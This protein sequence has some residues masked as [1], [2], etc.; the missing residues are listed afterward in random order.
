M[1]RS[2]K[3]DAR[4][5]IEVEC[6]EW[7]ELKWI[8]SEYK[9][10]ATKLTLIDCDGYKYYTS[11][12]VIKNSKRRGIKLNKFFRGN[13]YTKS[14]IENYLKLNEINVNLLSD[15]LNNAI[16]K[17]AWEC[18]NH[19]E[20]KLSWNEIKNLGNCPNCGREKGAL[21]KRNTYEYVKEEFKKK[22][23]LLI[24]ESYELNNIDLEYICEKH[25]E[26]GV[27]SIKYANLLKANG[28]RYCGLES[29]KIKQTKTHEQFAEE[30]EE[31][32]GDMYTLVGKYTKGKDNIEVFCN[33]CNNVFTIRA[34]HLTDNHGCSNCNISLGE[35]K[36]KKYLDDNS[37]YYSQQQTFDGC[38]GIQRKLPFDFSLFDDSDKTILKC[39]IEYQGIQ[40]YK[41]VDLFGGKAQLEA[42]Q[43][44]DGIKANYCIEN[45]IKLIVIPYWD[46][47]N[48]E[49]IL[50]LELSKSF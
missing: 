33:K 2:N 35:N 34:S 21:S 16:E 50:D 11:V 37:F 45:D 18:P 23:L 12:S 31:L 25:P 17:L 30:V 14:N 19:G 20:F 49:S 43:K 27:Q 22:G 38:V 42:Q 9:T 44:N 10:D 1:S 3:E 36:I 26:K 8:E 6:K 15:S 4:K 41:P 46:F 28:C 48:I 7:I 40:H 32:Y 47:K 29:A 5:F 13:E 24:S 39:L